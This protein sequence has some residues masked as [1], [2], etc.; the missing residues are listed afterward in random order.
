[1]NLLEARLSGIATGVYEKNIFLAPHSTT[2]RAIGI[3]HGN[4]DEQKAPG[5]SNV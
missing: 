5:K 3:M 4:R 2:C 1:M